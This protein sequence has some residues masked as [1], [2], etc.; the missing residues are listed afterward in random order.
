M[1]ASPR[2]W[3][4]LALAPLVAASMLLVASASPASAAPGDSSETADDGDDNPLLN[5]L[6][7]SAGRRF[8]A[9]R[10]AVA[11]STK[12]QLALT[13]QVR[14]AEAKRDALLP[15]VGKVAGQQYRTG[16][17]SAAGFLLNAKGSG[18]F[19]DRAISL[20]EI[21]ALNVGKLHEL[22]EAIDQVNRTKARL[23]QEVKARQ[24]NLATMERQREVAEN[25]LAKVG[26]ESLTGGYVLF[27]SPVAT[28]A[29]RNS[30]GG[31][32]PESCN[33]DDPTTSG[34]ITARTFHMYK[35][36]RK[37]GFNRFAGCHRFGGPFEHPKGRACDWS[38]Q[39][40]GFA[41]WHNGDTREYGNNLMAF[42]V[43]NADRLG[44]LYVIW[45]RQIWFPATGWKSYR[46]ASDHTDH[47]HVSML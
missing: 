35:Q 4:I 23:D 6:L 25:A 30:D 32:S 14:N 3:L 42:L 33:V 7:D 37:A 44:V 27:K 29:P 10:A 1:T 17:I 38:L 19:L 11:K 39:N 18:N 22:N 24:A 20:E 45:N 16:A 43:R 28:P 46:G 40:R 15:Q 2:R 31:F 34:C 12:T 41:R 9:A 26:G 21:N 5:E 36:V 13:V 47:V 8:L